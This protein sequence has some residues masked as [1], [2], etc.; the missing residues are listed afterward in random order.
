MVIGLSSGETMSDRKKGLL[1]FDGDD[2]LWKTQEV[3]NKIKT[4]F[5][6]L[7]ETEGF[8]T[9]CIIDELDS[10]DAE[11]VSI[12]KFSPWRFIES[13]ILTYSIYCGKYN[14]DWNVNIEDKI[15]A[16]HSLLISKPK[17]FPDTISTL[18]KL[19]KEY[20]L[21][22]YTQGDQEVQKAKIESLGTSFT[23]LF[24][25][26]YIVKKKNIELL[27][28]IK[29]DFGY[30]KESIWSIGNSIKSDIKPC[31]SVGFNCIHLPEGTWK[32]D[33]V[34]NPKSKQFLVCNSLSEICDILDV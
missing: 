1:I 26:I 19:S 7:M 14:I 23:N 29:N 33:H 22:L 21:V 8:A 32:Y 18:K 15:R 31:I 10:I 20:S 28:S 24:D 34:D 3:Y 25:E 2:T 5:K 17:I 27:E 6:K 16:Y 9:D 12:R 4:Y 11:R 30:E 13:M